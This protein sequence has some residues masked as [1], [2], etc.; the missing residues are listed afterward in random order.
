M[1][2]MTY[3]QALNAQ[4]MSPFQRY[5]R[6]QAQALQG[7]TPPRQQHPTFDAGLRISVPHDKTCFYCLNGRPAWCIC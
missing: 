4:K 6:K 1:P 3:L 5:L 7:R 2:M